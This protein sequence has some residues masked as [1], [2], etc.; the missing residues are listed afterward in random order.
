MNDIIATIANDF[1][2]AGLVLASD[3]TGNLGSIAL[4]KQLK[5]S[6]RT[7]SIK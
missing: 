7:I 3:S 2:K 6:P 4:V 1:L 5:Y